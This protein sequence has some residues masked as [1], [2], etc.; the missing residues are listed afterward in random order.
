M[1]DQTRAA[2]G[3]ARPHRIIEPLDVAGAGIPPA[4]EHT[5]QASRTGD[6]PTSQPGLDAV[7]FVK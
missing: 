3:P 7:R 4:A 5:V 1:S 6:R 2:P